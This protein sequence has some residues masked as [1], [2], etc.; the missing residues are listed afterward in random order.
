MSTRIVSVAEGK[1]LRRSVAVGTH[2]L[3]VDEPEPVGTDEG[4]TPGELLLAALGSCTSMAVRAYADRHGWPL[5]RIDV[6]VRFGAHGRI[7]KNVGLTGDLDAGQH[8][9]LMA[10]AGRCPVH[11]LLTNDVAIVTVP[12]L[13]A[14]P[15]EPH[16]VP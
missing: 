3:T 13:L 6:A 4:P 9:R 11:R 1:G 5:Y 10:V 16:D 15:E 12:T 7:I 2:R 14:E 8:E